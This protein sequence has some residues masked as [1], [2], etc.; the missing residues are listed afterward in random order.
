[1]TNPSELYADMEDRCD[2]VW[3]FSRQDRDVDR[4]GAAVGALVETEGGSMMA[5]EVGITRAGTGSVTARAFTAEGEPR[6]LSVFEFD[7]SV[8]ITG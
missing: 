7:D 2:Q 8:L 1:M 6:R 3:V 4:A 5:V